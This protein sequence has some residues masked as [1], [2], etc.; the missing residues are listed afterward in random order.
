MTRRWVSWKSAVVVILLGGLHACESTA[1]TQ[2]PDNAN[3][4]PLLAPGRFLSTTSYGSAP[5]PGDGATR[6]LVGAR[7]S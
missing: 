1:E 2:P 4:L 5:D 6:G 3:A 7:S